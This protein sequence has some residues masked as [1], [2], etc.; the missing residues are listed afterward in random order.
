MRVTKEL[1]DEQVLEA[2]RN[3]G[4]R[5]DL[6][7]KALG[8]SRAAFHRRLRW[9]HQN[10]TETASAQPKRKK[11]ASPSEAIEAQRLRDQVAM[12]RRQ[13]RDLTR[14]AINDDAMRQIIGSLA[15]AAPNPPA[16]LIRL[17]SDNASGAGEVPV[18]IWADWHIPEVVSRSETNGINEYNLEIA[19]R[20]VRRLVDNTIHVINNHG[21]KNPP[22]IVVNLAGDFV[23]G[24]LHPELLKTDELEILPAILEVRDLLLWGLR[25]MADTYGK[26]FVPCAAGNH[27]RMTQKP[28]FKRYVYKNADWFIY[29]MLMRDLADDPRITFAVN[30]ANETDYRVYG[31][32]I[33]LVHGDML[34]TAGG[35]GIIGALGPIIR[36]DV[37]TQRRSDPIGAGYDLL[38][39]GHWH[40]QI[41][42]QRIIVANTLKG[43]DE[44][45]RLRLNAPPT[46][47]TQPLF[48]VHRRGRVTSRWDI[49][50]E[51][52]KAQQVTEWVSWKAA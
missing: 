27:G 41:W 2:L 21:P 52:E 29:Q 12:L 30:D 44:F 46:E 5:K 49:L 25:K 13:V 33:K 23:S 51:Q 9:V 47:P 31:L 19:K 16:W 48:F 26:V 32:R 6:A 7:A 10:E 18:T 39:M 42:L 1:T 37:K 35:D 15:N 4:G 28:E 50:V 14:Q 3:S 43:Y 24:G 17:Q 40:Q 8:V 34:G 20:R 45:A 11:Q 36:G 38:L 22:G